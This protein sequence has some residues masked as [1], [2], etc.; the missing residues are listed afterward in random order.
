MKQFSMITFILL[1]LIASKAQKVQITWGEESKTEM[2]F[3]SFVKGKDHDMIKLAFEEHKSMFS[4]ATITPFLVRYNNKLDE[5]GVRSF[6]ADEK[7]V[8]FEKLLSVKNKLFLITSLYDKDEKATNYFAQ[9]VDIVSLN[10]IGNPI[11]L[12]SFDAI[13]KSSATSIDFSLSSD[14][15]KIL[16]FGIAPFAKRANQRYYIGVYDADLKK[17]WEQTVELP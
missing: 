16:L 6:G 4:K 5:T 7:G 13:K 17:L 1:S 3:N 8:V 15:S 12:G 2:V 14:S 10:P 9:K 11:S